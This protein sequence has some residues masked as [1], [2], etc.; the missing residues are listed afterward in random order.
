MKPYR[1]TCELL[2]PLPLRQVF[3]A[4]EDARNLARITPK[5]MN[6]EVETPGRIEMGEGAKIDYAIRWLGL[7]MKWRTLITH[8]QPPHRFIDEQLK[9]PYTLWRHRHTFTETVEGTLVADQ[10]D[11]QLPFG[12]LG[13]MAHAAI[14][15]RQLLEIFRYRQSK[16][17]ELLGVPC[18]ET[19]APAITES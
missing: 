9:G 4:F 12:V 15:K 2:A 7:P 11:Y 10:V 17:P 14:V 6:F 19:K 13:R 8:Y 3:P 16:M 18:R 5:W 1:L